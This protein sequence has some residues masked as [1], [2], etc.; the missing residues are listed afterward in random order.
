MTKHIIHVDMDAFFAAVEQRDNPQWRGLPVIVAG[1]ERR[2]V[3][4]TASYEARVFGVHSAM[5]TMRARSLCPDGIFVQPQLSKYS[6]VSKQVFQCFESVTPLIEGLSLD[7]AFLDITGSIRLLG[8]PIVIARKLKQAIKLRTQLNCSIGIANNKLLAK[9]ATEMG[10]PDGLYVIKPEDVRS[11]LDPLP[12]GKMWTV[13]KVSEAKLQSI[14]IRTVGEA[15]RA[16]LSIL[17]KVIGNH[18]LVL[19]RLCAGIDEREVVQER[20]DLSIGAETTVDEDIL[21]LKAAES[22]LMRLCERVCARARK[23]SLDCR[24]VTIKLR[25][26]PFETSTRQKTLADATQTTLEIYAVANEL[27][28]RWWAAERNPCLRLLGVSL[29]KLEPQSCANH[30]FQN[31]TV[32]RTDTV[33][34][35]IN[36]KFG[37]ISIRRAKSM[38]KPNE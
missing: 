33:M 19:K 31:L 7:E 13:G 28:Q 29:S 8:E 36:K 14:G 5:P 15:H 22:L 34:D 27:L 38:S 4:S 26:P 35:K 12:I 25:K 9:L 11:N 20:A 24:V 2:G 10:K 23:Q 30:L 1:S 37:G 17:Q 16:D 6:A 18:A 3:V 21:D 32:A